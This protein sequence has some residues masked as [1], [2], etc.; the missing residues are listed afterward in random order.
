M[1]YGSVSEDKGERIGDEDF[2]F[3][4]GDLNFR[5]DGLPGDDIRKLLILHSRGE[6]Y[7]NSNKPAAPFLG[8]NLIVMRGSESDDDNTA[9]PPIHPREQSFDSVSSFPDL[10]DTGE[11]HKIRVWI[12]C[13]EANP[14]P[15]CVADFI[16]LSNCRK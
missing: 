5:L 13:I 7:P 1:V 16:L 6:Y 10:L 14:R 8:E 9:M 11:F 2:A 15:L 4:F 12:G 3:W